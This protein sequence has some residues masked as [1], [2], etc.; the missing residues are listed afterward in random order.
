MIDFAVFHEEN[1]AI[2]L[3]QFDSMFS[4]DEVLILKHLEVEVKEK[5]KKDNFLPN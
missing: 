3:C 4:E 5:G 2:L 1:R